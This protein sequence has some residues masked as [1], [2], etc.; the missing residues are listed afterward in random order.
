[1]I[2]AIRKKIR[3]QKSIK[4]FL[5]NTSLGS[6]K[7]REFNPPRKLMNSNK[8]A[9]SSQESKNKEENIIGDTNR[10][11]NEIMNPAEGSPIA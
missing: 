9:E 4:D 11:R 1:M 7:T 3:L 8:R 10:E 5:S 2:E 6:Q